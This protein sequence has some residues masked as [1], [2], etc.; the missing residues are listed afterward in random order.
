MPIA[1]DVNNRVKDSII[2]S[3]AVANQAAQA[4]VNPDGTSIGSGS[5]STQYADG[6]SAATPTG[7][8]VNWNEAG[9]QRATSLTKPLPVQLGDGTNVTEVLTA[10][11][12]A[13]A[14]TTN[15]AATAGFSLGFNGTTWDRLRAGITAV[16]ST[17]TGWLNTLPWGIYHTTPSTRTDGQ[18]GPLET[19]NAGS[20]LVKETYQ[21]QYEDNTN[22][23][24]GVAQKPVVS[25]T[26]AP[27]AF[28]NFGA[29]SN[30]NVKATNAQLFSI[31]CQNENAAIRYL[32]IFNKASGPTEDSE[33]P[34]FSFPIP[35]GTAAAP[36]IC[37]RGRDFFGA[38]GYYLSTGLSW[39]ISV[40]PDVWDS[41]GI[42]A[43]EHQINGTYK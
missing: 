29:A 23:V 40:D 17:L 12:D 31:E 39:G 42:T 38:A 43:G 6:A 18:G 35:A 32:Q 13:Q 2:E 8:Q 26:Y 34:I 30:A 10:A 3:T 4:V 19:D 1:G 28:S 15:Q 22:Q 11:A 41:T 20:L 21:P 14:N 7:N 25:S 9:T 16:T 37:S 5:S 27:T 36:G 33:V 24:A